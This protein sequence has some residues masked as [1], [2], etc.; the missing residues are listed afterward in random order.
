MERKKNHRLK[1]NLRDLYGNN[2]MIRAEY[3]KRLACHCSE[4]SLEAL[5]IRKSSEKRNNLVTKKSSS[6][7]FT[8]AFLCSLGFVIAIVVLVLVLLVVGLLQ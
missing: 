8:L 3:L 1:P 4:E 2:C 6:Q 7:I 5:V